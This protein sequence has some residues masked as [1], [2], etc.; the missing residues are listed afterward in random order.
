MS[1]ASEKERLDVTLRSI[2]DGVITTDTDG[3][4]VML[5]K[6]AEAMTGWTSDEA[7][8]FCDGTSKNTHP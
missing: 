5:N 4:I 2:G 7:S 8:G 3:N 1:P 6:A